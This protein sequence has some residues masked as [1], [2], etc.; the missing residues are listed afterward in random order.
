[1]FSPNL[2]CFGPSQIQDNLQKTHIISY[3]EEESIN[4]IQWITNIARSTQKTLCSQ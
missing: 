1:M 3:F 4:Y 2:D